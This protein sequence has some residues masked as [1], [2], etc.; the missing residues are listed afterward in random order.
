MFLTQPSRNL[1]NVELLDLGFLLVQ[2]RQL[3]LLLIL[4][5][6][7]AEDGL[8]FNVIIGELKTR[9]PATSVLLEGSSIKFVLGIQF[10][11]K[12]FE[13]P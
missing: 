8:E 6:D 11:L 9:R 5:E 2:F 4:E 3:A 12:F 10:V 1:Q 13:S 7:T